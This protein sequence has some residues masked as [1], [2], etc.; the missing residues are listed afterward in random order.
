[1]AGVKKVTV[2]VE[3]PAEINEAEFLREARRQ[4]ARLV[5]LYTLEGLQTRTPTPRET[6][7]LVKKV[8]EPY[9][10]IE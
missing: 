7:E 1:M 6:K 10:A 9:T 3:V 4:L 5:L 2:E 8:K